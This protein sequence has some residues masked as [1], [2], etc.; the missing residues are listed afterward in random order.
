VE[1]SAP[2]PFEWRTATIVAVGVA[3]FELVI[4]LIIGIA[5][6]SQPG[7][8][9]ARSAKPAAHRVVHR[10]PKVARLPR[11]ET[12][13]LVL[14]ANGISGA[15]AAASDRLRARAYRIA[16]TG[17]AAQAYGQSV[18]LYRPGRRA[19]AKRLAR[20]AGIILVGPLDGLTPRQLHGAQVALV[21]GT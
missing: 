13:V 6:I 16:A 10:E 17:N 7:S 21:L 2:R 8:A 20:D 5:L 11:A 4:L 14:N 9:Q 12:S 3:A 15:A 1:I 18:V 19:E